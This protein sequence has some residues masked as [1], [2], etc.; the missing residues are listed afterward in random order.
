MEP[1]LRA[2]GTEAVTTE[3]EPK[4]SDFPTLDKAKDKIPTP[5]DPAYQDVHS[6]KLQG[7]PRKIRTVFGPQEVMMIDP[8]Y[9]YLPKL[10]ENPMLAKTIEDIKD[11]LECVPKEK[12][13]IMVEGFHDKK[14][15]TQAT[16]DESIRISGEAQ[17][18]VFIAQEAGVEV[19]SSEV[20]NK[21]VTEK[22]L[23]AGFAR[24]TS[25]SVSFITHAVMP[26][27]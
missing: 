23:A 2:N 6:V 26:S 9:S 8:K 24:F 16:L 19:I 18:T 14:P 22:C 12:Q 7:K 17:V 11:Y 20:D 4:P 13:F 25:S 15:Y 21:T 10:D 5:F 27:L 1:K 3:T